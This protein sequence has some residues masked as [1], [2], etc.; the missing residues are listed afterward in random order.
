M[1]G[2]IEQEVQQSTRPPRNRPDARAQCE[3]PPKASLHDTPN[4]DLRQ[5]INDGHDARCIIK[6]RRRDRRDRYHNDDNN[7]RFPVFTSNIIEKSYPKDFKPVGSSSTTASRTRANGSDATPLPLRSQGIQLH[8]GTLLL[9]SLGI[10]APH[11]A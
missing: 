3:A 5:K 9:G 1:C 11:L 4:I 2:N 6:A 8:Q 10:R 7:D